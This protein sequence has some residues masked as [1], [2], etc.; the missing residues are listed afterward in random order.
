[1][2]S[3]LLRYINGHARTHSHSLHELLF[4]DLGTPY[5]RVLLEK[6]TFLG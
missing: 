2:C 1:M 6:L 4:Y 5:S 3:A